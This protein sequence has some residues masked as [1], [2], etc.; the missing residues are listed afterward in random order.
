MPGIQFTRLS[1]ICPWRSEDTSL[2]TLAACR[3]NVHNREH[4]LL[5]FHIHLNIFLKLFFM[6]SERQIWFSELMHV[7]PPN[8]ARLFI[9]QGDLAYR[10]GFR[11]TNP[12]ISFLGSQEVLRI[13]RCSTQ[14]SI[15]I[16]R[17]FFLKVIGF[18]TALKA[19][20][21]A[22]SSKYVYLKPF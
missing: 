22:I 19:R 8:L 14:Y 5:V 6:V 12:G 16:P 3:V 10:K 1:H 11:L 20:K 4:K 17:Y 13:F 15:K 7:P 18:S 2:I 21:K 9:A